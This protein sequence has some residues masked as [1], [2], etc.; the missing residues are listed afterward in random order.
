VY[1]QIVSGLDIS[2]ELPLGDGTI[3]IAGGAEARRES[4]QIGAGEPASYDRNPILRPPAP[5]TLGSGAQGFP[6]FQPSNRVDVHRSNVS[7][8]L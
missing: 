7:G 6:G 4:F 2:K 1:D 5:S 8:Y 3:N